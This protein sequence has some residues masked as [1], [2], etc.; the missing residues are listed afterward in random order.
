MRKWIPAVLLVLAGGWAAAQEPRAAARAGERGQGQEGDDGDRR[1]H[2]PDGEDDHRE[3][4]EERSRSRSRRRCPWPG[5]A[6][7][8]LASFKSGRE[9][10]ARAHHGPGHEPE[11]VTSIEKPSKSPAQP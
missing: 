10:E 7:A 9:G 1:L 2:G 8:N 6:L 4:R 3:E 5:A 11:S